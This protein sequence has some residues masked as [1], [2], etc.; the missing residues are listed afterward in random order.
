[1][2][3]NNYGAHHRRLRAAL[4]P[5]A[6]GSL[7]TR[8][9]RPIEAGQAVDLDHTDDGTAYAGWAHASCNRRAGAIKGNKARRPGVRNLTPAPTPHRSIPMTNPC[10]IGVDIANDRSHT[11]AVIATRVGGGQVL[12]ELH[13]FDGS[14]TARAVADLCATRPGLVATV[15]DPQ[16]PAATLLAPLKDDLGVRVTE[17]TSRDV[18]LAHGLFLDELKAGRLRYVDHEALTTAVQHAM[19]RPLAGA[20]ALERRRVDVDA[21]PMTAAEVAVW[22][23]VQPARQHSGAVFVNLAD[24]L[25]D[26][27]DA[28]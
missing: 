22:A 7:C 26:D 15:V 28:V 8:C 2:G 25:D 20:E 27:D 14:D 10:A 3:L 23:L 1:M 17:P 5:F 13:Y 21:S 6:P 11:S 12:I 24:Y 16:S 19:A 4:L 18:A 9:R